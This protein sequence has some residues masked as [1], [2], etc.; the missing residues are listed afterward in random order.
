M[1]TTSVIY[2]SDREMNGHRRHRTL[3]RRLHSMMRQLTR[4]ENVVATFS[5]AALVITVLVLVY[6]AM[7]I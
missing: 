6:Q 5:L 4:S 2:R 7:T 3:S 1:Q